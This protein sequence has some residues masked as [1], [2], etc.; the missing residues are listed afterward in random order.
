MATTI[1]PSTLTVNINEEITLG[2]TSYDET[3]SHT[4]ENVANFM[5]KAISLGS[6]ATHVLNTFA[7]APRNNEFDIDDLK[8]IRVTNRDDTDAVIVNFV[9]SGTSVAAIEI[10]AGKSVVFFDTD[11]NGNAT[12]AAI[13]TTAPLDTLVI[14]NPNVSDIDVEIVIATA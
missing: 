5:K 10:L 9:D 6:S 3:V 13:T 2:A 11:M 12:G 8:Y 7:S 14:H 1:T 4:I